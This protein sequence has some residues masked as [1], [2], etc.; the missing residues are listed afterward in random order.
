[1][2]TITGTVYFIGSSQNFGTTDVA[3]FADTAINNGSVTAAAVF[4]DTAT[5]G[6][7]G[8]TKIADFYGSTTNAGIVQETA[9]FRISSTNTGS[10]NGSITFRDNSSNTGVLSTA[11]SISFI[12]SASNTGVIHTTAQAI[13][14]DTAVNLGTA[15]NA[16]FRGSSINTGI[17]VTSAIFADIAV[18]NGSAGNA[19][20]H[21]YAVNVGTIVIQATFTEFT[22]NE[23]IVIEKA[24]FLD[25]STNTGNVSGNAAFS[26]T[27]TNYGTI[28]GDAEFSVEVLGGTIDEIGE[29]DDFIIL[30]DDNSVISLTIVG[31][32]FGTVI[33]NFQ[34]LTSVQL[35]GDNQPLYIDIEGNNVQIGVY[36]SYLLAGELVALNE[37]YYLQGVEIFNNNIFSFF[38]DGAGQYYTLPT[39]YKKWNTDIGLI[40]T[41]PDISYLTNAIAYTNSA[42]TTLLIS[43]P[44]TYGGVNY[45]TD[46]GG[47]I[48]SNGV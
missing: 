22:I 7:N 38:S 24:L 46:S 5:N 26:E 3:Y 37:V 2:A 28:A 45:I 14:K 20:F 10:I 6:V 41:T 39:L 30:D 27:T 4:A 12:D 31:N 32:N 33:G 25:T 47:I 16:A 42:L 36:S 17:I 13:F 11:T 8:I 18:N 21:N 40:Y 23:G 1:M 43:T 15:A 9:T 35:L 44:F 48:S 19:T 29:N 34:M